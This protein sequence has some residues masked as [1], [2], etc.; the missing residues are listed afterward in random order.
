[1]GCREVVEDV[2]GEGRGGDEVR[3][4]GEVGRREGRICKGSEGIKGDGIGGEGVAGR[5]EGGIENLL[6]QKPL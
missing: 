2:G 4:G 1:M 6:Y 3:G 5:G